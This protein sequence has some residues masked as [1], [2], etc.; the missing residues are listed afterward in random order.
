[1]VFRQV[2]DPSGTVVPAGTSPG[3]GAFDATLVRLTL[4]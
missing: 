2:A 3:A 1:M 4:P